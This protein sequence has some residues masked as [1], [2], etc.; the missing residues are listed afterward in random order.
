MTAATASMLGA[1]G[2]EIPALPAAATAGRSQLQQLVGTRLQYKMHN[3]V[4]AGSSKKQ[5]RLDVENEMVTDKCSWHN[6]R[7]LQ[8]GSLDHD[9]RRLLEPQEI[10]WNQELMISE[11][12]A[13]ASSSVATGATPAAATASMLGA[14]GTEIPALPAAATASIAE[15][16]PTTNS[17]TTSVMAATAEDQ[18]M[19]AAAED[20]EMAATAEKISDEC[21]SR[22]I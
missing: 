5:R 7:K 8:Y 13:A 16:W 14:A 4:W 11:E 22:A 1:A 10:E 21:N 9:A 3:T 20:Q 17:P 12:A 2:T 6:G 19:A 18:E 15:G